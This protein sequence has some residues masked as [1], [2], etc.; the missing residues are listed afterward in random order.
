MIKTIELTRTFF[1]YYKQNTVN[2]AI[3]WMENI[4]HNIHTMRSIFNPPAFLLLSS[5]NQHY[6]KNVVPRQSDQDIS[7]RFAWSTQNVYLICIIQKKRRKD[8][9]TE[10]LRYSKYKTIQSR[11]LLVYLQSK[12]ISRK[13]FSCVNWNKKKIIKKG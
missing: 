13:R 7:V 4:T 3:C 8:R 6:I 9:A 1:Y 2:C 5:V 11:C 12:T 10:I